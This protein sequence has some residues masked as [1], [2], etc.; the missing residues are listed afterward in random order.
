MNSVVHFEIPAKNFMR[1]QKFYQ[2]IF[3][4][5][6]KKVPLPK[7]EYYIATTV[8]IDETGMP[9]ERGAINGAFLKREKTAK[10]PLLIIQVPSIDAALKKIRAKGGKTVTRKRKV[11]TMGFYAR[12][13]DCEGNVIGLWQNIH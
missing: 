3:G 5:R 7:V 1:A 6:I 11:A 12:V 9:K 2:E 13:A 10:Y 8:D 4:W